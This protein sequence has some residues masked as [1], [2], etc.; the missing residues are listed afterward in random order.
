MENSCNTNFGAQDAHLDNLYLFS[1]AQVGKNGYFYTIVLF[2]IK[3]VTVASLS[4]ADSIFE[5]TIDVATQNTCSL[6]SI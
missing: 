1:D 2:V 3:W 4:S 5:S 6:H